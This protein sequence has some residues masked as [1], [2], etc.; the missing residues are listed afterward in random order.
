MF[1]DRDNWRVKWRVNGKSFTRSFAN[2]DDARLFEAQIRSG[3]TAA[4]TNTEGQTMTFSKYAERWFRDY[5]Q[6]EKSESTWH[7]DLKAI[8][9]HLNPVLGEMKLMQIRKSHGLALKGEL[10]RKKLAPKTVNNILTLAK[11]ILGT[12]VD[13]EFI[14]A[15][16]FQGVKPVKVPK[17]KF[18]FWTKDESDRFLLRCKSAD[19]EFYDLALVALRTGLR[20]GELQALRRQDLDFDNNLIRVGA[21]F[22]RPLGKTLERSKNGEVEFVPMSESVREVLLTR[23]MARQ[24][25]LV[26]RR[27]MSV[28]ARIKLK[29]ICRRTNCRFISFHALRHS[30]ASQLAIAGV[31]L[32]RIQKL[33]RH[34]TI[35][36]TQRYAHLHPDALKGATEVL[37]GPQMARKDPKNRELKIVNS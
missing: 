34:K 26:F 33:M 21:T 30:F 37:D 25:D 35:T 2:K 23:A 16:P 9:R 29:I 8:E 22:S 18:D 19:P 27:A 11:K 12:A 7:N 3:V 15:N 10:S 28:R 1:R 24:G 13:H 31:D 6:V 17:P 5:A 4:P 20:L 32:Y 14:L 36:M